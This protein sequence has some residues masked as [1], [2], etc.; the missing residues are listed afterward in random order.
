VWGVNLTG[1]S[2]PPITLSRITLRDI[3]SPCSVS[4]PEE[5][6]PNYCHLLLPNRLK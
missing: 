5:E 2:N 1:G 3:A 4:V 6:N